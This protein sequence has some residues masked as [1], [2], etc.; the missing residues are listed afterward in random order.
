MVVRGGFGVGIR[1]GSDGVE[2]VGGGVACVVEL[3]GIRVWSWRAGG[4]DATES[5]G[6]PVGRRFRGEGREFDVA[7]K[8][9]E[10]QQRR[11]RWLV[12]EYDISYE[13]A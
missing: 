11:E 8:E 10:Q 1:G 3:E 6:E 4:R 2:V 5:R 9:V 7:E 13:E 12:A